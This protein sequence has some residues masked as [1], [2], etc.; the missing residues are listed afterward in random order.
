MVDDHAKRLEVFSARVFP[1]AQGRQGDELQPQRFLVARFSH[2]PLHGFARPLRFAERI[3]V[4]VGGQLL[5]EGTPAE[6][7]RDARVREVY[8]GKHARAA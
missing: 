8:L 6:V 7:G 5:M 2:C 1:L 4:L 3:S